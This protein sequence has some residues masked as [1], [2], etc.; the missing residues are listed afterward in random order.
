MTMYLKKFTFA[1]SQTNTKFN[2]IHN[3]FSTIK[4]S[5]FLILDRLEI[6]LNKLNLVKNLFTCIFT[7]SKIVYN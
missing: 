2:L 6:I 7:G 4:I 3:N 1:H 5:F